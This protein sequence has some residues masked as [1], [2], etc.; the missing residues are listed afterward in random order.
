MKKFLVLVIL[1]GC[2]LAHDDDD[3]PNRVTI[4]APGGLV[5]QPNPYSEVAPGS[6]EVADNI[7]YKRKSV[8]EPREGFVEYAAMGAPYSAAYPAKMWA[9]DSSLLAVTTANNGSTGNGLFWQSGATTQVLM[10]PLRGG[11]SSLAFTPG[12]AQMTR[13]RDRFIVAEN[14]NPVV[15]DSE[16]GATARSAGLPMPSYIGA[17]FP[18]AGAVISSLRYVSYRAAFRKVVGNYTF[19]GAASGQYSYYNSSGAGQIPSVVV[20][21]AGGTTPIQAG[22]FIDLYRT[23]E[24]LDPDLLG[25][26]HQLAMRYKILPADIANGSAVFYDTCIQASLSD[27]FYYNSGQEGSA[28]SNFMPPP[29][30]DV[31]TFKGAT[32]Y[33][34]TSSWHATTL[35][36]PYAWGTLNTAQEIERGIGLRTYTGNITVGSFVIAGITSP[37]G[38]SIGQR[39]ASGLYPAN[40]R[41]VTIIGNS[42]TLNAA[43]TGSAAASVFNTTDVVLI[44]GVDLLT[45]N[46]N[47]FLF[48]IANFG[49]LGA[50]AVVGIPL[51]MLRLNYGT[52]NSGFK[53]V[54][55][56][57]PVSGTGPFV[58]RAS[59]GQNYSPA[60]PD[61]DAATG[62]T[63][64]ND[65]RTN[66]LFHSKIDQ[67]ENVAPDA[68]FLVGKGTI[69]RMIP[70]QEIM[71]VFCTDGTYSVH[72]DGD[73]WSVTPFNIETILISPD[74]V[75]SLDNKVYA[76]TTNGL[77]AISDQGNVVQLSA[78]FIADEIRI[79][80]RQFKD[81]ALPTPYTWGV[82]LETD[83]FRNEVWF[84]FNALGAG[85]PWIQTYI[86]NTDSMTFVTQSGVKPKA[87]VYAP[88]RLAII[89]NTAISYREY[90]T[91]GTSWMA[92]TLRFNPIFATDAGKLRQW[93]DVT[94]LMEDLSAD[95]NITPTFETVAF[96][97]S[98]LLSAT[99]GRFE[100]VIPVSQD[101]S[102]NKANRFG[103]S[104]TPVSGTAYFRIIGLSFR[105]REASETLR[106]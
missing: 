69:L 38:L 94:L 64:K 100:H 57:L 25:D 83:K 81:A 67:P 82:Q 3:M 106:Q 72:G 74:A 40:T 65:P 52:A 61:Y 62:L 79:L 20:A 78:P 34:A 2:A 44:D 73:D 15:I 104:W 102:Y 5:K 56:I 51:S 85:E 16:G 80:Q 97:G 90:D 76:W 9:G 31:A 101:F 48:E 29:S 77:T 86:W 19:Q 1:L 93:L 24:Q 96:P 26:R 99:P 21:W 23:E 45:Q 36:V 22:D 41:V 58:V 33:N 92:P 12:K 4:L 66:R 7:Q 54:Q 35:S 89:T 46:P 18:T 60:L 71:L 8:I 10:S 88:Y 47:D 43:A 50:L 103:F 17:F 32:F 39:V 30:V 70:L 37:V 14:K 105:Y 53:G 75:T 63:S 84:N 87:L 6:L 98:Y 49:S 11:V 95:V 27:Y 55:L 42:I 91:A 68:Y 13:V 59:N 28:K